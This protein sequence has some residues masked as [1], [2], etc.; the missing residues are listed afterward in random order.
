MDT[1]VNLEMSELSR[2][3]TTIVIYNGWKRYGLCRIKCLVIGYVTKCVGYVATCTHSF[4]SIK[5]INS[6][7]MWYKR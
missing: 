6:D 4:K 2:V 5:S 1:R 7:V 3:H